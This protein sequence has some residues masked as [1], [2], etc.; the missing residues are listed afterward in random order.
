[1]AN[2][3]IERRKEKRMDISSVNMPFLGTRDEDHSSFQYL[4]LDISK[5]GIGFTIPTWV[6][7]REGLRGND[8]VNFHLP[9]NIEE[10]FYNQGVIAWTKWDEEIQGMICG[11]RLTNSE[12]PPYPV[13][14]SLESGEVSVDLNDFEE[15][16]NP[17][18]RMIK[19][20][21]LLKKGVGIYLDHLIPYFSR[22]SMYPKDEYPMLKESLLSD[23]RER[24]RDNHEKLGALY[25]RI[26]DEMKARS[27][28]AK[29]IDLEELRVM[30]ESEIY[31]EVFKIAFAN[32]NIMPYLKAVK[33]LENRLYFN[34]NTVV[35]LYVHSLRED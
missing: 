16:D 19:D 32:E 25:E 28:V 11:A 13:F 12:R 31:I 9:F 34:Y 22:I 26:K 18:C 17:L 24:V 2:G 20:A 23:I 30:I 5:N 4:V 3:Q 27:D 6:L 29:F 1:M 21:R 15:K 33:D 8:R 14:I 10:K 7:S 35:M